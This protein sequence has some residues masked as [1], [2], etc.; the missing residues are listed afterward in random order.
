M[1]INGNPDRRDLNEMWARHA[2]EAGV[3][4]CLTSDGH[5][6]DTLRNVRYAVATARR[7]WLTPKQVANTREWKALD[8]LR[9]RGA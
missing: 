1:E 2:A 6:I 7:A 3:H 8:K 5:G 9:K 4:I